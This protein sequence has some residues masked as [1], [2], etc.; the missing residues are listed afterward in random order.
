MLIDKPDGSTVFIFDPVIRE[1]LHVGL[2]SYARIQH[3]LSSLMM[4]NPAR[5]VYRIDTD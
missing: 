1:G 2:G 3:A 5:V 4:S